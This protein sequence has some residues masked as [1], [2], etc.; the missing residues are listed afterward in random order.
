MAARA[1]IRPFG[2][3]VRTVS[4]AVPIVGLRVR[5]IIFCARTNGVGLRRVGVGLGRV[6]DEL[7]R[8]YA[9]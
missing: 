5:T 6:E 8:S 4:S 2:W 9:G 7:G 1:R 3:R